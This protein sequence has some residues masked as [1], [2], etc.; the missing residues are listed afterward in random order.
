MSKIILD[1]GSGNTCKNDCRLISELIWKIASADSGK[2][3]VILKWQLFEDA[4]P[5]IQMTHEAFRFAYSLAERLGY[6]TTASVFD[7]PSL[8]FLLSFKVPFVKIACRP[9]LYELAHDIDIPVYMSTNQSGAKLDCEVQLA[10]IPKYPAMVEEYEHTFTAD[11]LGYISDHSV[12]WD[13]YKRYNPAIIEKH[14][15]HTRDPG[16][17]DAGPFAITPDQLAEVM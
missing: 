15:V 14:I 9:S 11:E 8:D 7:K 17:P 2:H 4:P 12:G 1:C 13:L 3:D 6:E 5:N 10:C 16:N